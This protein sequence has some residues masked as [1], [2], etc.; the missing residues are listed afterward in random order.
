[1]C[2]FA[3]HLISVTCILGPSKK[4]NREKSI[5]IGEVDRSNYFETYSV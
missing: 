3:V 4:A 5:I 2:L 1:M